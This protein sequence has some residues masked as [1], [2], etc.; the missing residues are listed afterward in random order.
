MGECAVLDCGQGIFWEDVD[1]VCVIRAGDGAGYFKA[2][3]FL[4]FRHS[5][6]SH[7]HFSAFAGDIGRL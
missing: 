1:A 2:F 4:S 7:S 3:V 6:C 5:G